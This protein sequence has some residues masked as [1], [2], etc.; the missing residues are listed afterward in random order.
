[1]AVGL[2]TGIPLTSS[3]AYAQPKSCDGGEASSG[4]VQDLAKVACWQQY[5]GTT[6]DLR[7]KGKQ[8]IIM[9]KGWRGNNHMDTADILSLTVAPWPLYLEVS[10]LLSTRKS[11][12]SSCTLPRKSLD[13]IPHDWT[14]LLARPPQE[15]GPREGI[16]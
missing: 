3:S 2:P 9:N 6:Q 4:L 10:R 12:L 14:L 1:V 8:G 15:Q 11:C 16:L 7:S 5:N 13:F